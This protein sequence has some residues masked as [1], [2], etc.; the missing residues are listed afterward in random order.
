MT[1]ARTPHQL[2]TDLHHLLSLRVELD[3]LENDSIR[4]HLIAIY[5]QRITETARRLDAAL[6]ATTEKETT[7]HGH[8]ITEEDSKQ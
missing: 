3:E 4:E 8:T 2:A 6:G 1:D 7:L 5:S